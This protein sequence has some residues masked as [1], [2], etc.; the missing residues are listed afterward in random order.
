MLAAEAIRSRRALRPYGVADRHRQ[1]VSSSS[2][3]ALPTRNRAVAP[4]PLSSRRSV[5][6]EDIGAGRAPSVTTGDFATLRQSLSLS[7]R[8]PNGIEPATEINFPF[9]LPMSDASPQV[10]TPQIEL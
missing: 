2:M 5:R 9:T 8:S 1:A 6:G 10:K 3:I 7:S 4:P